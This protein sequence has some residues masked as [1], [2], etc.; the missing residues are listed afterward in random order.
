MSVLNCYRKSVPQV[1]QTALLDPLPVRGLEI[2]KVIFDVDPVTGHPRNDLSLINQPLPP[3]VA[4]VL[5]Q[6]HQKISSRETYASDNDALG[7]LI[8]RAFQDT[9]VLKSYFKNIGLDDEVMTRA[10]NGD[11]VSEI[12]HDVNENNDD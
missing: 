5:G 6:L 2:L 12:L 11:S 4:T 10:L 9:D 3:E 7:A 8:P 1:A